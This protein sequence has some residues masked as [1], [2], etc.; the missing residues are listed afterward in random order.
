MVKWIYTTDDNNSTPYNLEG[1]GYKI[2]Y[3]I[4]VN[5]SVGKPNNPNKTI[6]KVEIIGSRNCYDGW[7]MSNIYPQRSKSCRY[8]YRN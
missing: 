4:D 1:F 5:P 2:L 6:T 3:V 8:L 7:I